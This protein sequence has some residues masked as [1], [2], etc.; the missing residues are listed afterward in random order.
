VVIDIRAAARIGEKD[1]AVFAATAQV[2]AQV[3]WEYQ[4]AGELGP[5]RAANLRWLSGYRHPRFDLEAPTWRA[6]ANYRDLACLASIETAPEWQ[7][8]SG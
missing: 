8:A 7:W 1:V 5:V 4:R 6:G 3:G 2:C